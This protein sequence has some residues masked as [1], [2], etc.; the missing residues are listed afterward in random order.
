MEIIKP[1]DL[2]RLEHKRA[3]KCPFCGCEFIAN[4]SEYRT[5]DTHCNHSYCVCE[6][7]TCHNKVFAEE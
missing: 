1:G 2:S 7:P 5:Y 6:C 3:F 4:K